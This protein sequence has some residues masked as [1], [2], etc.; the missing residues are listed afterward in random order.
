MTGGET[1]SSLSTSL[2]LAPADLQS[3][4]PNTD[5]TYLPQGTP[6]CTLAELPPRRGLTGRDR[7]DSAQVY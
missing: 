3:I 7:Q 1:L 2:G 4:N 5:L 6:L